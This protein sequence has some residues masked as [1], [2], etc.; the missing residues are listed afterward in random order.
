METRAVRLEEFGLNDQHRVD[1][2]PSLWKTLPRILPRNEVGPDDV[3]IDFGSGMG[4][5]VVLAA[6]RY[7]FR[8]IIGVEISPQLHEI[9]K[10]NVERNR[11]H[12][13]CTEI[14]LVNADVLDYRVPDDVTVA[15]LYNPFT[16]PVFAHV[17]AEL[18]RSLERNPREL[19]II[20]L[21]PAEEALLLG[22]ARV[23]LVRSAQAGSRV[24]TSLRSTVRLYSWAQAPHERTPAA[25]RSSTKQGA[26]GT[27]KLTRP[28]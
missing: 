27:R 1:H 28:L 21:N 3:L 14:E 18:N 23:S 7:R 20:Y 26:S 9:A 17:V 5:V 13:R 4:R 15:Y 6:K 12:L 2:V 22:S 25:K 10:Q 16:G 11:R 24:D 8:R 19:R